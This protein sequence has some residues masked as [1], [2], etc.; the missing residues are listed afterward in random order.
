MPEATPV[1]H[2]W[3]TCMGEWAWENG[4]GRMMGGGQSKYKG[5][6]KAPYAYPT[7]MGTIALSLSL[8]T[9]AVMLLLEQVGN[10]H[11]IYNA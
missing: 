7:C 1:S 10:L 2:S 6:C 5:C 11:A 9:L 3:C 4:H 8:H